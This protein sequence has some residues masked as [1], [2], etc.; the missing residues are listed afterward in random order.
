MAK[1]VTQ[2][3]LPQK[4]GGWKKPLLI[5][6]GC[7]GLSITVYMVF[8]DPKDEPNKQPPAPTTISQQPAGEATPEEKK[9]QKIL[10][11]IGPLL[12]KDN[13][14]TLM[15]S[16]GDSTLKFLSFGSL[17]GLLTSLSIYLPNRK[18]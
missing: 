2:L 1:N 17:M 4:W 5:T 13:L 12:D 15:M 3:S 8:F 10:S 14:R 18:R 6:I 9:R 16:T 11:V 7:V